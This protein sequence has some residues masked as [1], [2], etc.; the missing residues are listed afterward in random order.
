MER[1]ED[2][3]LPENNTVQYSTDI[4][5]YDMLGD[6]NEGDQISSDIRTGPNNTEE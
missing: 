6:L 2:N 1:T 4:R 3:R 5:K